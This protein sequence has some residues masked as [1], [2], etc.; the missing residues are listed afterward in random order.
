MTLEEF[1]E[2]GIADVV[3][4]AVGNEIAFGGKIALQLAACS[5]GVRRD[6]DIEIKDEAGV[7][8]GILCPTKSDVPVDVAGLTEDR[9]CAYYTEAPPNAGA[10]Y[11]FRHDYLVVPREI[12]QRYG[13]EFMDGAAIWGGFVHEA[14]GVMPMQNPG[15]ADE[16]VARSFRVF[17]TPSHQRAAARAARE[18]YVFER[19]LKLYHMLEL[20]FDYELVQGIQGLGNDL[21]GI[22]KLLSAY[23]SDD[24][25]RLGT[26]V[27]KYCKNHQ[28]LI[29]QLNKLIA[30]REPA[31]EIFYRFG[32]EGNPIKEEGHFR[33]MLDAGG[34]TLAGMTAAKLGAD[35][36]RLPL[37]AQN[38]TIYAIYRV[39]CCVAHHKIGEYLITDGDDIFLLEFAEPLLREVL[40]QVFH[41]PPPPPAPA[42]AV[43]PIA[44]ASA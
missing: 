29:V 7:I 42:V 11:T 41:R 1:G 19:F 20:L 24:M 9:L 13:D 40:S 35:P 16:I 38:L 2:A 8:L 14:P 22:A 39:R 36:G 34:I 23:R 4:E 44:V 31:C 17:V 5:T 10:Q 43:P 37:L 28:G 21:H 30:Y 25:N 3:P 12:R 26:L 33:A 6:Q 18:P 15:T 32:K 27:R